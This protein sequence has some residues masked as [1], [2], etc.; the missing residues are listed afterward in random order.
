MKT[1]GNIYIANG[2]TYKTGLIA[3]NYA[4]SKK[5]KNFFAGLA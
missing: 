1:V 4:S 2:K 5:I 3:K